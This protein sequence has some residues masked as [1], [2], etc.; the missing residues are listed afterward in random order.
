M[1]KYEVRRNRIKAFFPRVGT[2]LEELEAEYTITGSNR[3]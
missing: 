3:K 1:W 2:S